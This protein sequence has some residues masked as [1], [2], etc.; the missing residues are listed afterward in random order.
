M[1]A[2]RTA[3][4]S[5]TADVDTPTTLLSGG[6]TLLVI[7]VLNRVAMLA[8]AVVLARGLGAENYG[9]YAFAFAAVGLASV[10]ADFG[11]PTLLER[12]VATG[13]LQQ[14]QP[15]INGLLKRSS[16][17]VAGASIIAA[18]VLVCFALLKY[19]GWQSDQG[20]ALIVAAAIVPIGAFLRSWSGVLSGYRQVLRSRAVELLMLPMT[21]LGLILVAFGFFPQ[22]QNATVALTI[23]WFST[24]LAAVVLLLMLQ[25]HRPKTNNSQAQYE[26]KQWLR[27]AAPLMIVGSAS[28]IVALCDILM[29]GVMRSTTEVGVYRVAA[30]SSLLIGMGVQAANMI[31]APRFA[32]WWK[33]G[34]MQKMQA[35][36]TQSTRLV[37]ALAATGC[38]I[39]AL[40]GQVFLNFVFGVEFAASFL[41]LMVLCVGQ[42]FS[43]GFGSVGYLLTMTG[44]EQ[45]TARGMLIAAVVNIVLNLLF[46]PKWGMMGAAVATSISLIFWNLLLYRSVRK[47]TG[48]RPSVL[49]L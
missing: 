17:L 13:E 28:S 11:F 1:P 37:F 35:I 39:F 26:T 12:L 18:A 49:N 45:A 33:A 31:L 19:D 27:S 3:K 4:R 23:Q 48:L 20:R 7:L 6:I 34:E 8:L 40:V 21:A 5:A 30:Q 14:N 46:I 9:V 44:N 42:L 47:L 15:L 29:L 41:P 36:V 2:T 22:S 32:R 25:K 38:L 16:Q 10:F 43:V 24:V